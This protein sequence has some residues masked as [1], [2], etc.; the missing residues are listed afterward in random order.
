MSD[1]ICDLAFHPAT[2]I[3]A[4]PYTRR[5]GGA[6]YGWTYIEGEHSVIERQSIGMK[7]W[8][9][10]ATFGMRKKGWFWSETMAQ[11]V[12]LEQAEHGMRGSSRG[13]VVRSK[14]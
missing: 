10:Q 13:M 6:E 3:A 8:K 1:A 2:L 7:K 9:S 14:T 4:Q 11:C 12:L 5:R